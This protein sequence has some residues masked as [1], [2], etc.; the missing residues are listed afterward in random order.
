M[1][2]NDDR[3]IL[4]HLWH[5][6]PICLAGCNALQWYCHLICKIQLNIW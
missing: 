2:N 5:T 6:P 3:A 1:S 4:Q